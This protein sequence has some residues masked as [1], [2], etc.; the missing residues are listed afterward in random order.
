MEKAVSGGNGYWTDFERGSEFPNG[1]QLFVAD[2]RPGVLLD[3]VGDFRS[4]FA[5]YRYMF[6]Y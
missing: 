6:H 3:G 5:R 4:S 1:R 2:G